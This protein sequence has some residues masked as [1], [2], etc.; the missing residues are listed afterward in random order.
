MKFNGIGYLRAAFP[1]IASCETDPTIAMTEER[2]R[3]IAGPR[4]PRVLHPPADGKYLEG[5]GICR[6]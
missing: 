2:M 5:Q 6:G 3:A 1:A 4:N